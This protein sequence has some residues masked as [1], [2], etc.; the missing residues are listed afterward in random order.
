MRRICGLGW[1]F[2]GP[3]VGLG[4]RTCRDG[5]SGLV[6]GLSAVLVDAGAVVVLLR[7]GGAKGMGFEGPVLGCE[8]D[9]G[10]GVKDVG[11]WRELVREGRAEL[12]LSP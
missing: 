5:P 8:C 12:G 4:G 11:A 6:E 1:G 7:E 9:G 10:G 3:D 2:G